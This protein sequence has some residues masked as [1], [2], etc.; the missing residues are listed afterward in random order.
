MTKEV[1][2]LMEKLG[3]TEAEALEIIDSDREVDRGGN[4][5]PLTKEQEKASKAMR[6]T[7]TGVYKFTKRERKPNEDKREII[8]KLKLGVALLAGPASTTINVTNI[9]REFEFYYNGKKYKVVLSA[10]R[11]KKEE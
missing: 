11:E 4:P 1:K 8:E 3:V 9:E 7:S 10:P 2:N 5:N 6:K